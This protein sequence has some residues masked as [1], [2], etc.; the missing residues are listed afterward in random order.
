MMNPVTTAMTILSSTAN[1]IPTIAPAPSTKG[2]KEIQQ[3]KIGT[4]KNR[5]AEEREEMEMMSGKT[6]VNKN[7][8][9][10]HKDMTERHDGKTQKFTKF[11]LPYHIVRQYNS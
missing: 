11:V 4:A 9:E 2:M 1:S 7:M 3:E 10:R 6:V 8:T 5:K